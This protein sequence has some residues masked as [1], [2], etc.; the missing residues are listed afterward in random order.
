MRAAGSHP[1]ARPSTDRVAVV[2]GGTQGLGLAIARRLATLGA[3]VTV[4]GRDPER[5]ARATRPRPG[6]PDLSFRAVD[7]RDQAAVD[8][9]FE[10][11]LKDH[12]APTLLVN[13][14]ASARLLRGEQTTSHQLESTLLTSVGGTLYSSAALARGLIRAGQPGTIV[15]IGAHIAR[16]GP[17]LAAA[18]AGKAG[19]EALTRSLA[20]EWAP[21]GIRVNTIT[22]GVVPHDAQ[23]PALAQ[24]LGT[25]PDRLVPW[26]RVCTP[27]EFAEFVGLVA[28]TAPLLT[29][30]IIAF[31][32]GFALP[33]WL[34]QGEFTSIADRLRPAA[35]TNHDTR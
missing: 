32:G 8:K 17:G 25:A 20:V 2:T 6:E 35:P 19:V 12:G 27:E 22:P 10:G 11:V 29:G 31:D 13:A 26:G 15:N 14:A 5:G 34:H 28:L 9:A 16:G 24:S 1:S 33:H 18:A 30:Q 3:H 4:L 21:Y 23:L 7:V